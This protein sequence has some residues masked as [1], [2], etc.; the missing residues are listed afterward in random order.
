MKNRDGTDWIQGQGDDP[1]GVYATEEYDTSHNISR[2]LNSHDEVMRY[3]VGQV[4]IELKDR[5]NRIPTHRPHTAI[6][7]REAIHWATT[8]RQNPRSESAHLPNNYPYKIDEIVIAAG[9]V[10]EEGLEDVESSVQKFLIANR[11]KVVIEEEQ[12]TPEWHRE[13]A[14]PMNSKVGI[15]MWS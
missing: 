3:S 4:K 5:P 7:L 6:R 11:E 2:F 12:S 14:I 10:L 15:S 9:S 8:A 13:Y 1:T